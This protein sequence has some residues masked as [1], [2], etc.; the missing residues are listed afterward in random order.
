MSKKE[1]IVL[2]AC[3]SGVATSTVAQEAVKK[4]CAN[5]GIPIKVIKSTMN[6]IQSKQNDVD[7][8]MVTTNYRKP[9]TK[10]LIKVFGLIS[11]IG[12]DA[13]KQEIV[14]TCKK[15]LEQG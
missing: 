1:L 4:I 10:P 13:V 3:G 14:D 12:E 5:E 11:G 7:V 15:L 2:V 9:V 8:I 6:E